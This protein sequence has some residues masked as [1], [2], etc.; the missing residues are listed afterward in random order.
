MQSSVLEKIKIPLILGILIFLLI[1]LFPLYW[2]VVSS[3]K[4]Q[5]DILA[6][7]PQ[8]FPSEITFENYSQVWRDA[9]L[10]KYFRNSIVITLPAMTLAVILA[11]ISGYA[12][13]RF[14]FPGK[15]AFGFS[16]ILTQLFPGVLFLLPYFL[17]FSYMQHQ[18]LFQNMNVIF[19]GEKA[20]G[21]N[22][23]LMIFTYSSFILPFSVWLMPQL[24]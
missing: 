5:S 21:W 2:L 14:Q 13:S 11:T 23:V 7:V 9:P 1:V 10:L 6:G 20:L 19:M 22:Y 24:L 18:P 4:T 8:I 12:F 15:K 17:M 3:L 16:I